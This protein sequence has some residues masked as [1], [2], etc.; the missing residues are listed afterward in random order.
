MH[1]QALM[2]ILHSTMRDGTLKAM[3]RPRYL[4]PADMLI[5]VLLM[6]ILHSTMRGDTLKCICEHGNAKCISAR[7]PTYHAQWHA[8]PCNCKHRLAEQEL[9]D[10]APN[11]QIVQQPYA[12]WAEQ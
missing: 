7:Q 10:I 11:D 1:I 8:G 9:G 2:S 5:Q 4:Y 12:M 3:D 6:S